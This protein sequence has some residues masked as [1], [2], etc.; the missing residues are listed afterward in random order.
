[1]GAFT[2][3]PIPSAPIFL[4]A[5]FCAAIQTHDRIP[6]PLTFA[7]SRWKADDAIVLRRRHG[8]EHHEIRPDQ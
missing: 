1:M 3:P 5:E 6:S 4:R 2:V 7:V 8:P